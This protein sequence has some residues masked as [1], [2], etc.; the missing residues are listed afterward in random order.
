MYD[1]VHTF[2]TSRHKYGSQQVFSFFRYFSFR[3][4]FLFLAD[5]ASPT[6]LEYVSARI[7]SKFGLIGQSN[8]LA[9]NLL[10]EFANSTLAYFH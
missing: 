8:R 10:A 5:N 4:F 7:W 9:S 6:P 2:Y 1:I 3:I